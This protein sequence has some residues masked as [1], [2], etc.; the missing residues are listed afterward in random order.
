MTKAKIAEIFYS[1]QGEGIYQGTPQ[2]FL[3]FWGC[4]LACD[5]C[6]T[7]PLRYTEISPES[8]WETL[9]AEPRYWETVAL[10]GGEPLL[11][12][13]A[14]GQICRRIKVEGRATYLETNGVLCEALETVIDDIDTIAMDFKLPSSTKGRAFWDEHR[15]FLSLARKR[16]V[17]V[18]AV[19]TPATPEEEIIKSA[20]LIAAIDK[21][22]F[23]VLQPAFAFESVLWE[24]LGG[25]EQTA[26]EIIPHVRVIGQLHKHIGVR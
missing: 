8:I 4:D 12:A 21:D 20:E 24:R 25:F 2:I 13:E 10:T 22:I 1:I 26:K 17:F 7:R 14:L 3:R 15:R 19:V 11:Q 6:D 5:F 16:E 9:A 23:L 18:K